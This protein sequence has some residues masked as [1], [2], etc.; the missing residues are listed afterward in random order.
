MIGG[1]AKPARS[2]SASRRD[3][4][5]SG[6][7][8]NR[9]SGQPAFG[10][11][12]E[13]NKDDPRLGADIDQGVGRTVAQI[14]AVLDR[15]DPRQ[16]SR[17]RQRG[18]R[19][20]GDAD[21]P[22]RALEFDQSADRILDRQAMIEGM[23]LAELDA[24]EPQSLQALLTYPLQML[25]PAIDGPAPWTR[26][27]EPAFAGNDQTRQIRVQRLGDQR[28]AD[29]GPVGI[30]G[31]DEANALVDRMAKQCDRF[32]L[33]ARRPP[34][35]GAGDAHCPEA[36]TVDGLAVL[37][38]SVIGRSTD[39]VWFGTLPSAI[40]TRA[41]GSTAAWAAAAPTAAAPATAAPAA[42]PAVI[43]PAA[44]HGPTTID[45]SAIGG[46]T[47]RTTDGRGAVGT[48]NGGRAGG[49]PYRRY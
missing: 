20:V 19:D 47:I 37:K 48:A 26:S 15:D 43:R 30:G 25:R 36:E 8:A 7:V 6:R 49:R 38:L 1:A 28:F 41:A 22:A 4:A 29:P 17:A 13:A 24:I 2:V 46:P 35:A 34:D 31:V 11:R 21:M 14:V 18:G 12:I 5:R 33:G 23:E 45:G 27:R 40:T 3:A 44:I 32:A 16:P 42:T 39:V 9:A 10:E